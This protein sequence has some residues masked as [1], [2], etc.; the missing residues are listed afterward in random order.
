M[1]NNEISNLKSFK[2][3]IKKGDKNAFKVI[4][5]TYYKRLY[6][7]SLNYV[8]DKYAAEE[9]V[10]NVLLKL[11]QKRNKL[12][13][14]DNLK[15]YLY[16][17][18]RNA[19]LDYI[20]KEKKFIRLDLEKHDSVTLKDQF[21]IEEETYAVLFQALDTLPSKCRKVFELSCLEGLKYKDIAEDLQISIN[22]VK[23]QRARAIELLKSHLKNHPFFQILLATL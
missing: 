5:N 14:I 4:F 23:S 20:K 10:E 8:E 19:S 22:T 18:V 12:D 15:S 21:I 11:W 9:I 6:L 1:K 16:T 17:M 2:T 3:L 13:K 7:F